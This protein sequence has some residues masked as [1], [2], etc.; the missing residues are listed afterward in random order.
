[1]NI[2]VSNVKAGREGLCIGD[3]YNGR[4]NSTIPPLIGWYWRG[5]EALGHNAIS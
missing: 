5:T 1:M 4:D 3:S 2:P